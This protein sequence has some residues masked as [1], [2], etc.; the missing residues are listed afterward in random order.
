MALAYLRRAPIP[1]FEEHFGRISAT[2]AVTT[3]VSQVLEFTQRHQDLAAL[4]LYHAPFLSGV[5]LDA[6]GELD[7]WILSIRDQ[8]AQRVCSAALR[9]A[10]RA[11]GEDQ[12]QTASAL[13]LTAWRIDGPQADE[14]VLRRIA[15]VLGAAHQS[16][17]DGFPDSS[18]HYKEFIPHEQSAAPLPELPTAFYGREEEMKW[19]ND[20]IEHERLLSV[21]GVAGVGKTSLILATLRDLDPHVRSTIW[22]DG[23]HWVSIKENSAQAFLQSMASLFAPLAQPTSLADIVAK[24]TASRALLI[25]DA[26]SEGVN[27]AQLRSLLSSCPFLRVVYIAWAPLQLST[28]RLMVLRGFTF[29]QEGLLDLHHPAVHCVL[30]AAE[31]IDVSILPPAWYEALGELC[32][33][34]TGV[35]SLLQWIGRTLSSVAPDVL[36][37]ALTSAHLDRLYDG[38]D[39]LA[40]RFCASLEIR[41]TSAELAALSQLSVIPGSFSWTDATALTGIGIAALRRACQLGFLERI[42][43]DRY[44]WPSMIARI[45]RVRAGHEVE[46]TYQADY[47]NYML[48][49]LA[50][51]HESWTS[52]SSLLWADSE[53]NQLI[54]ALQIGVRMNLTEMDSGIADFVI[55]LEQ[56]GRFAE[57]LELYLSLLE[58]LHS[59]HPLWSAVTA[60]AAWLAY[61]LGFYDQASQLLEQI[62]ALSPDLVNLPV[63]QARMENTW[64][65]LACQEGDYGRAATH[66]LR[67]IASLP[68]MRHH[69][70]A[71]YRGNLASSQAAQGEWSLAHE[72]YL[73]ALKRASL[74]R[75]LSRQTALW[76]GFAHLNLFD[77][78][79]SAPQLIRPLLE[80]F[81]LRLG[82]EQLACPAD[83]WMYL[84][85]AQLVTGRPD[86]AEQSA[87]AGQLV[88]AERH[89]GEQEIAL[90]LLQARAQAFQGRTSQAKLHILAALEAAARQRDHLQLAEG[91][92]FYAEA[93]ALAGEGIPSWLTTLQVTHL[94]VQL[95]HL[96]QQLL[97]HHDV[98]DLPLTLAIFHALNQLDAMDRP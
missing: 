83:L 79:P 61:R 23:I 5:A 60:D 19:L 26:A 77:R 45:L 80:E 67:A 52:K 1:L 3:D 53:W 41:F 71:I 94:D 38:E 56:S 15:S 64:G 75:D 81:V 32:R 2:G 63:R 50:A 70:Q 8:V 13:A 10:E 17:P 20:H 46:A 96:V 22:P 28:E 66:F 73:D 89:Q 11:A 85:Y 21:V 86:L 74:S 25:I 55:Y 93:N 54:L 7:E 6:L 40:E 84:G 98:Q 39:D 31:Q 34:A 30:N 72:T 4:E 95:Q 47:A 14:P 57:G 48:N 18:S 42:S 12:W 91:L 29:P 82:Q 37:A 97:E 27:A 35:P 65:C 76:C 33:A 90:T 88:A 36:L 69:E 9:Q 51:R 59:G 16:L 58:N 43:D 68:P 62:N 24:I 44:A 78:Q 87:R 49:Q 92:I